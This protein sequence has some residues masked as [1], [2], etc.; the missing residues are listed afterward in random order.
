M[1]K[2]GVREKME[3]KNFWFIIVVIMAVIFVLDVSNTPPVQSSADLM[4][5]SNATMDGFGLRVSNWWDSR[6]GLEHNIIIYSAL[7]MMGLLLLKSLTRGG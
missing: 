6:S 3:N 2:K 7:G 5:G 1:P 4:V